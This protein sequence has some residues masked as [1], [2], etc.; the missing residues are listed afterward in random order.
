[1]KLLDYPVSIAFSYVNI[2]L[3]GLNNVYLLSVFYRMSYALGY[4]LTRGLPG[5][6]MSIHEIH[7]IR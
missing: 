2:F 7:K 1:M 4:Q 5:E 6:P 3:N